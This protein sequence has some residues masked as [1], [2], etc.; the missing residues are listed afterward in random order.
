MSGREW[1]FSDQGDGPDHSVPLLSLQL[2]T[3]DHDGGAGSGLQ[4]RERRHVQVGAPPVKS[5]E[6]LCQCKITSRLSSDFL[7]G[8][9]IC[10]QL[11]QCWSLRRGGLSR[12]RKS[13]IISR[14]SE[15]HSL[16]PQSFP[17]QIWALK[18]AS[19]VRSCLRSTL[20]FSP[21]DWL[22]TSIT[23]SCWDFLTVRRI[24]LKRW[25]QPLSQAAAV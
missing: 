9:S 3:A 20:E 5:P 16:L 4:R 13:M 22:F 19:S 18:S 8:Q 7:T 6:T 2:E 15:H 12:G 11:S 17:P 21:T 1:W 14:L 23:L 25:L 24:S 10:R